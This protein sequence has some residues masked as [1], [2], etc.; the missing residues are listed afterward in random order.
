MNTPLFYRIDKKSLL[1]TVPTHMKLGELRKHLQQQDYD[2][3]FFAGKSAEN[4]TVKHVL[5][6]GIP[7][8]WHLRYG[9][10]QDLCT[11]LVAATPLGHVRTKKVPRAATGPDLKKIFMGSRR[12]YGDIEEATLQIIPKPDYRKTVVVRAGKDFL[13]R[14]WAGGVRPLTILRRSGALAIE[15]EG[16]K[17]VVLAE[18]KTLKALS[19][20]KTDVRAR[21]DRPFRRSHPSQKERS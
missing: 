5:E 15:L 2:I 13:K 6:E 16:L 14:L 7:N 9:E 1:V 21:R 8:L 18:E 3:G 4:C 11:S 19:V 17:D 10:I 12:H 20:Q